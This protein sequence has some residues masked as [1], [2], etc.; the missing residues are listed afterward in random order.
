MKVCPAPHPVEAEPAAFAFS[1]P[2]GLIGLSGYT[3]GELA[4]LPDDPPFFMLKLSGP[5]G[6]IGFVAVEPGGLVA[7]YEIE[8]FEADAASIDLAGQA[9][10]LVLNIVTLNPNAPL[11]ATL[12][13]IGPIVIN[14]RTLVGR[15]LVIANNNRYSARHRL[16]ANSLATI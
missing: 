2:S 13:L 15:Q 12:N 7:D 10:A 4:P 3:R 9:D 6:S 16:M 14:R 11:D 5:A 1:L 8:L